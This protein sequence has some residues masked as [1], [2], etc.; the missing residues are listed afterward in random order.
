MAHTPRGK[1]FTAAELNRLIFLTERAGRHAEARMN[2]EPGHARQF[3][4][5]I[6][7]DVVI[8]KKLR[9]VMAEAIAWEG[10]HPEVSPKSA[11][12]S[13]TAVA[14]TRETSALVSSDDSRSQ[15]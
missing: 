9:E 2:R 1:H 15:R 12:A 7:L 14:Q 6:G 13:L 5:E 4:A 8:L 10:T 11:T 3:A